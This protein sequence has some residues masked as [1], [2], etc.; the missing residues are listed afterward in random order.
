MSGKTLILAAILIMVACLYWSL[1]PTCRDG[2]VRVK[3]VFMT[4]CVVG[5]GWR[6]P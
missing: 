3:G 4:A 2:E 6:M 1:Q 5:H